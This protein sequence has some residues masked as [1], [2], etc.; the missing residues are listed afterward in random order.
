MHARRWKL[1]VA[2]RADMWSRW[3]AG[4]S[5]NAIGPVSRA[6]GAEGTGPFNLDKLAGA[7]VVDVSVHLNGFG[8]ERVV[9]DALDVVAHGFL[10][11]L[12]REPFDV[13]AGSRTRAFANLTE[14][15]GSE[16]GTFEA[17]TEEVAHH[18]VGEELHAA[19]G[20]MNDKEF[21]SA[22][23]FV[24]DDKGADGVVTGASASVANH[25]CVAFGE[26]R[27]LGG[28]QAG[29]HAGQNGEAACGGHGELTLFAKSGGIF[30]IGFQDLAENLA[31]GVLPF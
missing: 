26:T 11:V 10:L 18:I 17:G 27:E 13:F 15:G 4:Q 28:V 20:V 12:D 24:A 7:D 19:V 22:E 29:V 25:V 31:H 14:T 3:K 30:R 6:G 8:N 16:F 5:L 23:K 9:A 21:P 2:Q 1:S